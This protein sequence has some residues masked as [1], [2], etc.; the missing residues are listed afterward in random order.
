VEKQQNVREKER[1]DSIVCRF[2]KQKLLAI[3]P[4][5]NERRERVSRVWAD[6]RG[7]GTSNCEVRVEA[8]A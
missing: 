5:S 1:Q 8:T 2:T 7:H 6:D 3:A 4:T